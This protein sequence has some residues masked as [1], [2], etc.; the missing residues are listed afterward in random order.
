MRPMEKHSATC[1]AMSA[2]LSVV[3][4]TNEHNM[5]EEFLL[6]R[7]QKGT[8]EPGQNNLLAHGTIGWALLVLSN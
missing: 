4:D 6:T 7:S 3:D 1:M 5:L 8:H 2:F